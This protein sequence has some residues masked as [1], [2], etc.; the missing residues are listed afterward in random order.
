[1]KNKSLIIGDLHIG[2]NYFPF[3]D[4]QCNPYFE[5]EEG[6]DFV[7]LWTKCLSSYVIDVFQ[8]VIRIYPNDELEVIFLGDVI[9]S[10]SMSALQL[11]MCFRSTILD[12]MLDYNKVKEIS[13][14]IGN[15]DRRKTKYFSKDSILN[16]YQGYRDRVRIYNHAKLSTNKRI[17]YLPYIRKITDLSRIIVKEAKNIEGRLYIMSH[18]RIY[19]NDSFRKTEMLSKKDL[20]RLLP[21]V[22]PILFNGHLH[23]YYYENGFFL[24]GSV[25][26]TSMKDDLQS[27]GICLYDPAD[28]SIKTFKNNKLS[29][30]S[31]SSKDYIDKLEELLTFAEEV[32]CYIALKISYDSRNHIKSILKR[33]CNTIVA[34]SY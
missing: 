16:K 19:I 22:D 32:G 13:V 30:L 3:L 31:I 25:A 5:Y 23:N 7:S 14:L 26:P 17:L 29:F 27:S 33:F 6:E 10:P 12:P 15:H 28:D 4:F 20:T 11:D 21:N 9:D 2:K 1:M 18:N 34:S 8:N 24:T